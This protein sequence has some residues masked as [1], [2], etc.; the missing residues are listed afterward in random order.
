MRS[1]TI[2]KSSRRAFACVE[3]TRLDAEP[4]HLASLQAFAERAYRRPLSKAERDDVAAFY[5]TLRDKDGL[6]HEDAVRDTLVSVLVS[7]HFLF[8]VD[9]AESAPPPDQACS[10]FPIT[11][12]RAV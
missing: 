1:R 6:S 11:L 9:R 7:P 3:K 12:L 2:S 4:S 10:R 8:R 5:R